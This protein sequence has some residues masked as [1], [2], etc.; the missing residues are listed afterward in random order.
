MF[1]LLFTAMRSL[2]LAAWM[3]FF[4]PFHYDVIIVDQVPFS[5]PILKHCTDKIL[6]YC[7]FPDKFL[8]PKSINPIRKMAYRHWFDDWEATTIVKADRILVNSA[9]TA[10][11]FMEAFPGARKKPSVLHPGVNVM[12]VGGGEL[13]NVPWPASSVIISSLN[14][15]ERKKNI[16]LAIEAFSWLKK[17]LEAIAYSSLRLVIAGKSIVKS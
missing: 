17:N 8:A 11:K 13:Q 6:F 15:F 10:E 14:R 12:N 5:I 1:H 3:F 9:F 4:C 7:H 16:R 2:Y